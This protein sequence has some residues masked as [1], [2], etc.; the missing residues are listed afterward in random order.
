MASGG[1]PI[2]AGTYAVVAS[3]ASA[4]AYDHNW[5]WTTFTV[6]KANTKVSVHSLLSRTASS[7]VTVDVVPQLPGTGKPTGTVVL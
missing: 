1:A 4:W 5:A 6:S 2:N 3:F 7:T